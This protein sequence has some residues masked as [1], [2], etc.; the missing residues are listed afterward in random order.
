MVV[1]VLIFEQDM[2]TKEELQGMISE[3]LQFLLFETSCYK[4][5][6]ELWRSLVKSANETGE[7]QLSMPVYVPMYF[8]H[9]KSLEEFGHIPCKCFALGKDDIE[10]TG[11]QDPSQLSWYGGFLVM[12]VSPPVW[13]LAED[14]SDLLDPPT[15][16]RVSLS[17]PCPKFR[18]IVDNEV[19]KEHFTSRLGL[20]QFNEGLFTQSDLQKFLH[21][22]K[23]FNAAYHR[24]L[25]QANTERV[26]FDL[27]QGRKSKNIFILNAPF[28]LRIVST[29]YTF[30]GIP[31]ESALIMNDM[32][33]ESRHIPAD[34]DPDQCVGLYSSRINLI[35][36]NVCDEHFPSVNTE[37]WPDIQ[38]PLQSLTPPG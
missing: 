5:I 36:T 17:L 23:F 16:C 29:R 26:W 11:T 21:Q 18:Q 34:H 37:L 10:A 24:P 30:S 31:A 20:C 8:P 22:F 2:R 38:Q 35:L 9:V 19:M 27:I 4:T 15:P 1:E 14:V 25:S 28:L 33:F 7:S 32:F 3:V 6:L 12:R 13:E